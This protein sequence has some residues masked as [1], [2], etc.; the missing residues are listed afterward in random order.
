MHI[1]R[2]EILD[3]LIQTPLFSHLPEGSLNLLADAMA[4]K[5]F[6]QGDFIFAINDSSEEMFLIS[7]GEIILKLSNQEPESCFAQLKRGDLFGVL[8][9][10]FDDPR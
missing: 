6:R 3:L 5:E 10:V 2:R 9:I 8:A 7:E 1:T 4:V